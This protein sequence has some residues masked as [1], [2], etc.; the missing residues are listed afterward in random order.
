NRFKV[1]TVGLII[2]AE[3]Q[4]LLGKR[5]ETEDAFPGYRAIPGGKVELDGTEDTR[6]ILEKSV[7]RELE[8][9]VGIQVGECKYLSSHYGH[10][11][12]EFKLYIA[13]TAKHLGGIPQALDETEEIKFFDINDTADLKLAP[14][15]A[16][17]LSQL[18]QVL[19]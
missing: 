9:E 2:N 19:K 14:N 13:F 18:S 3:H 12:G 16:T 5:S 11:G 7:Q 15:V 6:N 4:V 1:I 17:I 8:E 10:N